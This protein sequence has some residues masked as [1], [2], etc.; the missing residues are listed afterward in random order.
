MQLHAEELLPCH[1]LNS[2]ITLSLWTQ[3]TSGNGKSSRGTPASCCLSASVSSHSLQHEPEVADDRIISR[4]SRK[5]ISLGFIGVF[6]P[7]SNQRVS[8]TWHIRRAMTQKASVTQQSEWRRQRWTLPQP[9]LIVLK[10]N[11]HHH[12]RK[13]G[14][15]FP[16]PTFVSLGRGTSVRP[17]C[18]S[19]VRTCFTFRKGTRLGPP[20]SDTLT[21]RHFPRW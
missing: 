20:H 8:M 14:T 7:Q 13:C 12:S 16:K 17:I 15:D 1:R 3:I 5:P 19:P 9:V 6:V 2:T 18:K 21:F 11:I 10:A 4:F